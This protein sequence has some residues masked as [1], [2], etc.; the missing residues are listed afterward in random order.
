MP[1]ELADKETIIIFNPV[2]KDA[3]IWTY[4]K[5]WQTHIETKLGIKP[6][7]IHDR[8]DNGGGRDYT[9][10]KRFIVLPRRARKLTEA[11][12]KKLVARLAT[13]RK[14]SKLKK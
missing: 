2:D 9:V 14:G 12:R 7:L 13:A 4:D 3:Q 8:I 10:P 11:N 5:R 1:R 6:N